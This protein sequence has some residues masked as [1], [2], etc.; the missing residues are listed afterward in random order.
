VQGKADWD[1]DYK[2]GKEDASELL[3]SAMD[4]TRTMSDEAWLQIKSE[5]LSRYKGIR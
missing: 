4:I 2:W 5:L 1:G 3:V